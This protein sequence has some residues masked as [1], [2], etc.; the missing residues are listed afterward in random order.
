MSVLQCLTDLS[1]VDL[2]IGL[3]DVIVS[4][5]LICLCVVV[6]SA[7]STT[8]LP[9][10]QSCTCGGVF[11]ARMLCCAERPKALNCTYDNQ[12]AACV[13]CPHG[14]EPKSPWSCQSAPAIDPTAAWLSTGCAVST[15][16]VVLRH[17]TADFKDEAKK[18]VQSCQ[19]CS[20]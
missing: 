9:A 1:G 2:R 16:P 3:V 5:K 14:V 15:D 10:T 13:Q 12:K 6:L 11:S 19:C 20:V 7:V 18:E 8:A 17:L 4:V